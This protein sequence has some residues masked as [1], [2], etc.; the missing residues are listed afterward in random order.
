MVIDCGTPP[1]ELMEMS[2]GESCPV[3]WPLANG[4]GMATPGA[5]EAHQSFRVCSA[6]WIPPKYACSPA[7]VSA[8]GPGDSSHAGDVS[9]V[10]VIVPMG[11][12]FW[13]KVSP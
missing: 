6:E 3:I 1:T 7:E 4:A 13:V 5:M 10:R 9:P 2:R 11:A 12:S 8:S